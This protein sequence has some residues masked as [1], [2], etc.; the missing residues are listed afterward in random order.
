[1]CGR[2]PDTDQDPGR[3]TRPGPDPDLVDTDASPPASVQQVT[4]AYSALG[5]PASAL[6]PGRAHDAWSAVCTRLA[7]AGGRG[8][9][10][11]RPEARGRGSGGSPSS[12]LRQALCMG[13]RRCPLTVPGWSHTGRLVPDGLHCDLDR[14][15]PTCQARQDDPRRQSACFSAAA[16][17]FAR[18]SLNV[19]DPRPAALA[20]PPWGGGSQIPAWP[21]A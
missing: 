19:V 7:A 16:A 5:V 9:A 21:A 1:M 20:D 4:S 18:R 14:V 2:R 12:P 3:P 17:G 13:R 8:E 6:G 11:R 10:V 15:Y